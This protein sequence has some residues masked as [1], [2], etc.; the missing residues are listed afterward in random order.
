MRAGPRGAG[1]GTTRAAASAA[2]WGSCARPPLGAA[3]AVTTRAALAAASAARAT[4]SAPGALRAAQR[5]TCTCEQDREGGEGGETRLVCGGAAGQ[6]VPGGSCRSCLNLCSP[7]S[8]ASTRDA[9]Q[10]CSQSAPKGG[11]RSV[12]G[13]EKGWPAS[14]RQP[15]R[16]MLTNPKTTEAWQVRCQAPMETSGAIMHLPQR[17]QRQEDG[18]VGH[19]A[20]E[21][22][23]RRAGRV[24][25]RAVGESGE[26]K[27]GRRRGP[28]PFMAV[29]ASHG[30]AGSDF[31]SRQ[32]RS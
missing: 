20:L 2:H 4:A 5:G 26:G 13:A 16:A 30:A 17:Y 6:A 23:A 11:G 25:G 22:G 3:V 1:W 12:K 24:A 28:G 7:L 27:C 8:C 19:A 14:G 31:G 21:V 10:W 29:R 18:R 9:L 15:C 32:L